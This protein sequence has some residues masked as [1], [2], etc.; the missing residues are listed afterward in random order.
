MDIDWL[1]QGLFGQEH[2]LFR[3]AADADAEYA[4][5]APPGAHGRDGFYDPVNDTVG[6]IKHHE[7]RFC[8]GASTLGCDIDF[9][10]VS[11]Y[12]LH[13]NNCRG[14]VPGI[15]PCAGRVSHY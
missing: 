5:R 8:L 14:V 1:E 15:L 13:M 12:Q 2:R 9:N 11:L 3:G 10:L 7:F 6:R 4:G